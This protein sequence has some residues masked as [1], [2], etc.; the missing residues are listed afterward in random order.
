MSEPPATTRFTVLLDTE[1]NARFDHLVGELGRVTGPLPSHR[2]RRRPG[3]SDLL[4]A[5]LV[6]LANDRSVM[7]D[8]RNQVLHEALAPVAGDELRGLATELRR[9]SVWMSTPEAQDAAREVVA[10][11]EALADPNLLDEHADY[12]SEL[13]SSAALHRLALRVARLGATAG[14]YEGLR[15]LLDI[16]RRLE[17]VRDALDPAEMRVCLHCNQDVR[18]SQDGERFEQHVAQGGDMCPGG[19]S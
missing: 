17:L 15:P 11:L 10:E 7:A 2:G 5:A 19:A 1:S 16:A 6:V 8:V 12:D 18:L 9:G 14:G 4:R 13:P 3:R